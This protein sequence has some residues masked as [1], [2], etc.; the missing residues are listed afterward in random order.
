MLPLSVPPQCQVLFAL[1]PLVSTK[2]CHVINVNIFHMEV[3]YMS[4][5]P[6]LGITNLKATEGGPGQIKKS[7][8][9]ENIVRSATVQCRAVLK[10]S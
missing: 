7:P 6:A 8:I 1:Q 3:V 2:I 4:I 10:L 5:I 9:S